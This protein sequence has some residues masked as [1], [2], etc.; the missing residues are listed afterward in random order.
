MISLG[1]VDLT[2]LEGKVKRSFEIKHDFPFFSQFHFFC[3]Y[4]Y[5]DDQMNLFLL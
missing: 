2:K 3:S 5:D 4:Y 1:R